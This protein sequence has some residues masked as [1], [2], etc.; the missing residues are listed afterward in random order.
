MANKM[1]NITAII[2][3]LLS[4]AF[5]GIRATAQETEGNSFYIIKLHK[6]ID[7][8]SA[9]MFTD[10]LKQAEQADAD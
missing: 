4:L 7:A 3:T 2:F 10:A 5:S 6:Q 8:S 1:K 9:R